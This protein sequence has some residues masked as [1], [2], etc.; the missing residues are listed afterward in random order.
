MKTKTPS[1]LTKIAFLLAFITLSNNLSVIAQSSSA[2]SPTVSIIP[3]PLEV[4]Y[5]HGEFKI[6]NTTKIVVDAKNPELKTLGAMLA[7]Y[8]KTLD[9]NLPVIEKNGAATV[10]N[11]IV[12][13]LSHVPDTL[14]KEGYQLMVSPKQI[15][16]TSTDVQGVFYAL[17]SIYQLLPAYPSGTI[18]IPAMKILDKPRFGWR[19]MMLDVGRHFYPV[20]FVKKFIDYLAMY[21]MNSFH[22][23]LTED[24]GWRIE[25]KKYPKLTQVGAWRNE[26]MVGKYGRKPG[27]PEYD[28][29][30]Y[31]GFYTQDQVREIV[32]YAKERYI[33]V[34]PEIEM[35]GHALAALTAYPEL[36][37]TGG[38]FEVG[39]K[40][41]VFDD[42]Y[43]A[44]NEKTFQF[45][46]DVLSE[47][48]ELFPSPIIHIGGDECPKTR[49]KACPK[50]QERMKAEGL[51]DEHELQSYFIKRIE[52]FLL[53]KNRSIIGWDEILEG[54]LAPNASVMSWRGIAGGIAAAKQKHN[55]IM[56]PNSYMYINHY[57]GSQ[58]MEPDAPGGILTLE[59]VYSYE[60]VPT[61]LAADEAQYIKGVQANLWTEYI[62]TEQH[63][64]YMIF[65]RLAA[66]SEVSWT[67]PQLKDWDNFKVRMSNE[68]KRYEAK[69]INY[70][71]SAFNVLSQT[72]ID[73]VAQKATVELKV[74]VAAANIHYTVDN[75]EPTAASLLYT[76]PFEVKVPSTVK[77]ISFQDGQKTGKVVTYQVVIPAKK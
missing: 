2:G 29:M 62:S 41:G 8:L 23:H 49:W 12:L 34:I 33:T 19:G 39:K 31:G 58:D 54:G 18:N 50:C 1:L 35:P 9:V 64:E 21:K 55:V 57:Q 70:S 38:P 69:G 26:T 74:L 46:E 73:T 56:S 48:V 45:L 14:G 22:W 72:T 65:P 52:K 59:K 25:I 47:V 61:S 36:S 20:D 67:Q 32:A 4:K 71:R 77:A 60:P 30:R 75:S 27:G 51:K 40:W 66:V 28:H 24:Q 16:A 15:V 13:T 5:L 7:K 11:A 10:N 76:Q 6:N 63:V 43:C 68:Y 37:C 53:T 3:L 17:Q 44:G 42:V